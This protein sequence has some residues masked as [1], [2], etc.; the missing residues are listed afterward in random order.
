MDEIRLETMVTWGNVK[1]RYIEGNYKTIKL[2]IHLSRE[3]KVD[4]LYFIDGNHKDKVVPEDEHEMEIDF[5]KLKTEEI[6]KKDYINQF[7]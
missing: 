1:D 3:G 4:G 7:E 2:Y 5:M 6:L